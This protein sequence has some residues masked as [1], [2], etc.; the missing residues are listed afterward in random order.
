MSSTEVLKHIAETCGTP[1]YVF[2]LDVLRQHV[3]AVRELADGKY[4]I[5]YSIKA[6]PF[7]TECM[8]GLTDTLEVCSPGELEICYALHTA[9][10]KIL[11]SGV[12][13]TPDMIRKALEYGIRTFTAESIRHMEM[14]E[15]EAG[16]L[17]CHADVLLRKSAAAQFG[18]SE[19]DLL[20]L[21]ETRDAYPHVTITG[22]HYFAGTMQKK[23][24]R[25]IKELMYLKDLFARIEQEYGVRLAKLEY[26]PGMP[27]S[28]FEGEDF[29]DPLKPL[30]ALQEELS[31]FGEHVQVTME[32]GRFFAASCGTYLSRVMDAKQDGDTHYVLLDGGM[33]QLSYYGQ[34]MGMKHPV[35]DVLKD[36]GTE[37][38]HV[39]ICGALCTTADVLV[40]DIELPLLNE[41]DVLA[42]RNAGAYSM[43]EGAALFLSRDLPAVCLLEQDTV[44]CVRKHTET[45]A[46]N[47][48]LKGE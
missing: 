18:M 6:N 8:S 26:G 1:T 17:A 12:V 32:A 5:C 38:R 37:T 10:E 45:Y 31:S 14:L 9:P 7:I 35:I 43:C 16:K 29:S 13:K 28:L 25:K 46:W 30:R 2:D 3:Q 39:C 48:P 15:K 27:A 24:E 44:T 19:E 41:G 4:R 34:M 21:I 40:R 33:H 22:I 23:S 11:V 20:H 36:A 47:T 42:F